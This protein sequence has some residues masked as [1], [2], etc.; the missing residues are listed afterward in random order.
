MPLPESASMPAFTLAVPWPLTV[1]LM[2]CVPLPVFT[3]LMVPAV[4]VTAPE[5]LAVAPLPPKVKVDA[6]VVELAIEPDPLRPP[7]ATL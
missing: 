3:R 7:S 2:V 6:A 5:K 1:P 4:L